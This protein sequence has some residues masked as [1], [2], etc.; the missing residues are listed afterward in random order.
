MA[1]KGEGMSR[2]DE[3]E[4]KVKV[5]RNVGSMSLYSVK[6]KLS[7]INFVINDDSK[8]LDINHCYTLKKYRGN[9]YAA[10]LLQEMM[11]YCEERKL[12]I[13]P[14]CSYAKETM[15]KLVRL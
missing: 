4:M 2:I 1:G 9:G 12:A 10:I 13:V 14:I 6:S 7:S 15:P 8:S 11:K 5:V 3:Y